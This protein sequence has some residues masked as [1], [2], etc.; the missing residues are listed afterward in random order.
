M[1]DIYDPDDDEVVEEKPALDLNEEATPEPV[2]VYERPDR[3]GGFPIS[4][5]AAIVIIILLAV[6]AYFLFVV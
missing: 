1:V 4:L 3:T 5:I 2:G 6:L